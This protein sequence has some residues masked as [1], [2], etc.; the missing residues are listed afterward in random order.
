MWYDTGWR[1][2]VDPIMAILT[3]ERAF[4]KSFFALTLTIAL[5]NL[6]TTSMS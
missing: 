3:R 6:V 4:Y 1:K 5:Q 2:G